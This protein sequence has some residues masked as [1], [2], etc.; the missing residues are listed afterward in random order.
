MSK[1]ANTVTVRCV[2]TDY[3]DPGYGFPEHGA[4]EPH[5][6]PI[7][8]VSFSEEDIH[9]CKECEKF[10]D[11]AMANYEEPEPVNW[12]EVRA[13]YEYDAWKDAQAERHFDSR[14]D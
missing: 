11:D 2:G 4:Q 9:V 10:H 12:E 3:L 1:K 13:D 6:V 7:D 8:E 14:E 5:D